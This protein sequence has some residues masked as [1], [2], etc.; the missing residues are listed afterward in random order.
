MSNK[1][2]F[3]RGRRG[4]GIRLIFFLLTFPKLEYE[5]C[6]SKQEGSEIK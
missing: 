2:E 6:C 3:L 1:R 5:V 4:G